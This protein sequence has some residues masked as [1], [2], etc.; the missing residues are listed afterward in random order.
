MDNNTACDSQL[1][2][3]FCSPWNPES[4]S[5]GRSLPLKG[6][7]SLLGILVNWSLGE[8]QFPTN[9]ESGIPKRREKH[10]VCVQGKLPLPFWIESIQA[11]CRWEIIPQLIIQHTS[12]RGIFGTGTAHETPRTRQGTKSFSGPSVPAGPRVENSVCTGRCLTYRCP[13]A[14]TPLF[15]HDLCGSAS[16]VR[17]LRWETSHLP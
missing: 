7:G 3:L 4:D 5:K 14:V 9:S 10:L 11:N 12:V 16:L 2:K 13:L 15:S 1:K 17:L 8:S 6:P